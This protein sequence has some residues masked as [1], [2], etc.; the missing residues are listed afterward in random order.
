MLD[1]HK[2]IIKASSGV[3][4]G[5][6]LFKTIAKFFNPI[7]RG[8][9]W[10]LDTST[11]TLTIKKDFKLKIEGTLEIQSNK[12][13]VIDSGRNENPDRPGYLH[14]IWLNSP[15][16][17]DGK[18]LRLIQVQHKKTGHLLY[19]NAVYDEDGVLILDDDFKFPERTIHS[20]ATISCRVCDE[21]D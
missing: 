19:V 8:D 10:E 13:I 1:L 9:G 20:H 6:H 21:S 5:D 4:L 3:S 17:Q 15:K 7:Q 18:P 2:A 16:D 14:S 12:D 11:N